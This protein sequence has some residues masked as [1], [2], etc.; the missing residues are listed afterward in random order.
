MSNFCIHRL[1]HFYF[2][3][4]RKFNS[5]RVKSNY[6]EW[7]ELARD[8]VPRTRHVGRAVPGTCAQVEAPKDL[9]VQGPC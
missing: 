9:A 3:N 4:L 6:F 2:K 1:V 7:G 5:K 8:V